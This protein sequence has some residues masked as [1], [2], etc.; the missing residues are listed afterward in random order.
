[1]VSS[2]SL[3]IITHPHVLTRKGPEMAKQDQELE[4]CKEENMNSKHQ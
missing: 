3:T 4:H 1:M 2:P